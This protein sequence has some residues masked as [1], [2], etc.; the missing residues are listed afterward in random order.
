MVVKMTRSCIL[1]AG[2]W[3]AVLTMCAAAQNSSSDKELMR[4]LARPGRLLLPEELRGNCAGLSVTTKTHIERLRELEK[5]AKKAR[6][7]PPPSLF[8]ELPAVVDA[9]KERER[10]QALNVVLDAK[11]CKPVNVEEELQKTQA[12]TPAPKANGKEPSGS[13]ANIR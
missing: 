10:V 6:E 9:A 3:S 11:G 2:L 12:P 1:A 4:L 8:G 7:G 13:K 5:Q